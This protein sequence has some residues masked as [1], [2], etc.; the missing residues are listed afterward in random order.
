MEFNEGR[1]VAHAYELLENEEACKGQA[2]HLR[3]IK[4]KLEKE[5]LTL[6]IIGQFK[7][8]KSTLAN[9]ILGDDILPVGIVPITSAVTRVYYGDKS[10]QVHFFNGDIQPIAFEKLSE[11]ISEQENNNNK[12]GVSSVVIKAP[13]KFLKNGIEFVDTPGVGSF[14]KNNTEVAYEYMKESDGVIF[15]LSVDSPINE[16]EIEF[17]KATKEFASKFYFAVNK[18]DLVSEVELAQYV[19]YCQGVLQQI[20][21]MDKE[22]VKIFPVSAKTGDGIDQLTKVVTTDLKK[23]AKKILERSSVLK[24]RDIIDSSINQLRFYWKAMNMEYSD[25]DIAF[26]KIDK[27]IEATK[28]AIQL[29]EGDF[30]IK[31]NE[32]K[33]DLSEKV[34]EIFGM[35]YV[36]E[37]EESSPFQRFM[38]KEEFLAKVGDLLADLRNTLNGILL[39]REDNAYIVVRRIANINLLAK[40]LREIKRQ[41]NDHLDSEKNS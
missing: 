18:A 25:L 35:E 31:F 37:I 10:A 20:M 17:L 6:S 1:A 15:L 12:L 22:P 38:T 9:A 32:V 24:L 14:H 28:E 23:N 41:I 39:Y 7:R 3:I 2:Q 36:Y 5:T 30:E 26:E 40:R 34:K 27:H 33:I 19:G 16:I 4:E 11:Y 8:G 21:G 13:S 29:M